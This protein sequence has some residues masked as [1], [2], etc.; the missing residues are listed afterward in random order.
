MNNISLRQ[1]KEEDA[2]ALA[3]I[4]NNIKIWN[5]LRDQLPH[6]YTSKDA[7]DWIS[8][9]K[10]QKPAINF[11]I[12]YNGEVAGSVGC[13]PKA[14][15]YC[16]NVEIGYFIGEQFWGRGIATEAVRILIEYIE[17]HFEAV[18]IYAEVFAHNKASMKVLQKNGFYLES[19]R[20]KGAYKNKKIIDDYVWVKLL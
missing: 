20:R 5:N 7:G 6:P 8:H 14:D 12:V 1:W 16:R 10:K 9:C 18:R 11:A 19:I 4:A 17:K 3:T 15:V 2:H 13:V